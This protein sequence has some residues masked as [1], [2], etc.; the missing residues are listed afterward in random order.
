MLGSFTKPLLFYFWSFWLNQKYHFSIFGLSDWI[1]STT[2]LF[3][4]FLIESEVSL[5]Y[6]WSFWLDQKHRFSIF[7]LSDWIRSTAF[8]FLVFLIGSEAPLFYFWSFW[9]DQKHRF[10][11]F[12]LF[13]WIRSTAFSFC[14]EY[15][16]EKHRCTCHHIITASVIAKLGMP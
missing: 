16:D 9:L 11:I 4:V 10:S 6:F 1:K 12:G 15:Q 2:F 13:D 8:P 14:K 5:F 7:G 3:L